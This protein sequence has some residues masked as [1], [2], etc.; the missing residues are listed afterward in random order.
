MPLPKPKKDEEKGEWIERCMGNE[1][2]KKEFDD[3]DQRLAVCYQIWKDKEKEKKS[4]KPIDDEDEQ[5]FMDRCMKDNGI[6]EKHPDDK[7]R[8][9]ACQIIWDEEGEDSLKGP[10][11]RRIHATSELRFEDDTDNSK[12]IGYAAVFNSLSEDMW[13]MRE[14]VAP[15]AFTKTIK[16]DD[17]RAL[18]NHDPNYVLARNK[19]GTLALSEDNKGL[20]VNINPPDTQWAKDLKISIK[21]G[22]VNQMSFAFRTVQD[23]W[24]YRDPN[25]VLRTLIEVTL[26]DVSVVTYPAYPETSVQ[27]RSKIKEL[28]KI[29]ESIPDPV[30]QEQR[31]METKLKQKF[32]ETEVFEW[33]LTKFRMRNKAR[34]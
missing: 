1:T 12:I 27:V 5:E 13:G 28:K 6:K 29:P 4:M 25:E 32:E 3:N 7:D 20:R 30:L 14:Q 8:K 19:S 2:M 9:S 15:G 24:D 33:E 17:V 22:D 18:M 11:E 26:Y 16:E 10:I 23:K 31:D 34:I 21:R